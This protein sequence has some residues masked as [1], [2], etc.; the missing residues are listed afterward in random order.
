[1]LNAEIDQLIVNNKR[2]VLSGVNFSILGNKIYTV[3][4]LNGSGKTTLVK[5][6]TGLLDKRFYTVKGK[7]EFEGRDILSMDKNSLA[8][9]RLNKIKYVF[10]DAVNSFDHLKTFDYYFKFL[11]KNPDETDPMLKYFLLPKKEQLFKMYPYEVSGGMA[12]RINFALV[13]LTHPKLIILD[14]PTSGIDSAISNL[15]MLKLKDYAA[16]GGNS[17]LLVTH[18]LEFARNISDK[19][20]FLSGGRLSPFYSPEDFFKIKNGEN[21]ENFLNAYMQLSE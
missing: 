10:Q 15:F 12:Q 2:I 4:G 18:N 1:M 13:L 8:D 21:L 6:L 17:A 16:G 5:S 3:L 19:I 7:V 11:V 14:E 20:A 9:I